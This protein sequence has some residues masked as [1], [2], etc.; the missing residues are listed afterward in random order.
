MIKR[1]FILASFLLLSLNSI[2]QL[3][4]DC[5]NANFVM[6]DFT[7][8]GGYTGSCCP[9]NV[10]NVGIVAGRH[11]IMNPGTDP[12][13]P[14]LQTVPTGFTRSARLGNSSTGAQAEA[15][16]YSLTV[17]AQNSLFIYEFAV[18]M[19][20]PGH[21]V[22]EQP[23]FELQVVNP[24]GQVIPCTYYQ[25]AAGNGIPGFQSYSG[26]VW[27]NWAR[28]GVS[29]TSFIGQTVTIQ[30]KTGD[31][32]LGGHYGY[33]Y[34]VAD[35][36]PLQIDI[37]YCQGDSNA[38]LVAP[39]GFSSYQWSNGVSGNTVV[40]QNPQSGQSLNCVI[41][42]A[43][44]C[45]ATLTAIVNPITAHAGFSDIFLCENKALL[46]DTS[47]AV[48]GTISKWAWDY[49]DGSPSF[50]DSAQNPMHIFPGPGTYNV[51][52]IAITSAGCRDTTNT[53]ITIY[54]QPLS[55]LVLP[56]PCGL[57]QNFSSLGTIDSL[58]SNGTWA[59]NT[60][61]SQSWNFLDTNG[62]Q[63]GASVDTN[64]VFT[65]PQPGYY[66]IQLVVV[67][68]L[69]C[70]DTLTVP[71]LTVGTPLA[72]F[73][74]FEFCEGLLTP[75]SDT[76]FADGDTITSRLWNLGDGTL[77]TDSLV[78]NH[79]YANPGTYNA[80]LII[81]T[82]NNCPDTVSIPVTVFPNPV[83][84]FDVDSACS[85]V[86][87]NFVN[88]SMVLTPDSVTGS[89]WVFDP[90]IGN[91][92][93]TNPS[94]LFPGWGDYTAT[95]AVVTNHGCVDTVTLPVRVN[96]RPVVDF[97]A[98]PLQG[99]QPLTVDM[100]NTSYVPGSDTISVWNWTMGDGGTTTGVT[101]TYT[102]MQD[103]TF[104]VTLY[105]VTNRG[106]DTTVTIP[107]LITV[108]PKPNASYSWANTSDFCFKETIFTNNQSTVNAPSTIT[109]Y[110]WIITYPSG[111]GLFNDTNQNFNH[112]FPEVGSYQ[113]VLYIST[114]KGCLD[115]T[116]GTFKVLELPVAD[117]ESEPYCYWINLFT[118]KTSQGESPYN[119]QWNVDQN[120]GADYFVPNFE[121][122]YADSTQGNIPVVLS[123]TDAFGCR[124]DTVKV[125]EVKGAPADFDFPNV[126]VL[127]PETVGND[128]VQIED[129]STEFNNCVD[130]ELFVYNRWGT[131]VFKTQNTTVKEG[132]IPDVDCAACFRGLHQDG[133]E[134]TTGVYHYVLRSEK[135]NITKKGFITVFKR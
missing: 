103:G 82:A 133:T 125:I 83:A 43:S 8:W 6:G 66:D 76:S 68:S 33:G 5:P 31:C 98:D 131:L 113:V 80:Q 15:L 47:Y 92:T 46:S 78:F 129:L 134:L 4:Q 107:N 81:L 36:A 87:N 121:H 2:A 25:V 86:A 95:L 61:I 16:E 29:L 58:G 32:S 97:S 21:G 54:P 57:T 56:G 111:T 23:R 75:F 13:V 70:S 105:A 24:F 109:D 116:T 48:N 73:N 94:Q 120:P 126:L 1:I 60:I 90:G 22:S 91:S 39:P 99:C 30:A 108:H 49:G 130:Y 50:Q 62:V 135:R 122:F 71:Y 101:P 110:N 84:N 85:G 102:Y 119:Y 123:I 51:T 77:L 27:R 74:H 55:N 63:V 132:G 3:N 44:G 64:P 67:D 52:Q 115:T 106:C 19:Q 26:G 10:P 114:E 127:N 124:H 7:N 69:G 88:L 96:P 35:C 53:P 89:A 117:F 112:V 11:T 41:T 93:Q 65:F 38:V 20:D 128:Q 18:V 59:G 9:I 40:I 14:A 42:S 17:N 34:L 72:D 79:M 45:T 37:R 104:S 12:I 28:V 118:D 100:L